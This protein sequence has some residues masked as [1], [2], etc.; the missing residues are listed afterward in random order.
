MI[1]RIVLVVYII[2]CL[3]AAFLYIKFDKDDDMPT[4][5]RKLFK[6]C[7]LIIFVTPFGM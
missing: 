1:Y 5:F 7:L 4:I 3:G 2:A 6:V